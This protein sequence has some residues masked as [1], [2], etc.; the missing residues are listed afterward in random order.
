MAKVITTINGF[1]VETNEKKE[2]TEIAEYIDNS[3]LFNVIEIR[4]SWA[5]SQGVIL[6]YPLAQ[7][8]TKE[9]LKQIVDNY[10]YKLPE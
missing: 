5:T 9:V 8:A 1:L 7:T 3:P 6:V 2:V 4:L 10:E